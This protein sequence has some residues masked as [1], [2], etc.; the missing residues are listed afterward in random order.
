MPY[1]SK[2]TLNTRRHDTLALLSNPHRL[3]AT[4]LG[5]LTVQPV[6]ERVLW[7]LDRKTPHL[8]EVLVLTESRP[9]WQNLLQQ[10]D[11]PGGEALIADYT[12]LLERIVL[13]RDFAFRL[14]ANPV[15]CL[16]QPIKPSENQKMRMNA[17]S[18]TQSRQ[19]GFRVAYRTADQ[20]I[21]WLL[22]R[23]ERHGFTI[24]TVETTPGIDFG[25]PSVPAPAVSLIARETLRF[26]KRSGSSP[27][28]L[29][30][31]TFQGQL[32]VTRPDDLRAAL[33]KGIG[34]AKGY[35]QGLLTLAPL[36]KGTVTG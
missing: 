4:I 10:A 27:I 24:P 17:A 12:P 31:V 18:D 9:S 8:A 15:Q 13:G 6:T 36:P 5:G 25:I 35:G 26:R 20:Q 34:P 30:T 22:T 32:R 16:Q 21:Q 3:H 19:R 7:R 14:R 29:S 33:L 28:T 2:I 11:S 23:A 1:L